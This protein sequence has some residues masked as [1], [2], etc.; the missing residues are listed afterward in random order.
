MSRGNPRQQ[1][2][3]VVHNDLVNGGAAHIH[4]SRTRH[5][6]Q[7]QQAKQALLVVVD[8][9]YFGQNLLIQRLAG[10][11]DHRLGR[12][13]VGELALELLHE[14]CLKYLEICLIGTRVKCKKT[15]F[16]HST[17]FG[18]GRTRC[19]VSLGRFFLH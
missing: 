4:Q 12:H 1:V 15:G 8:A 19:K 18:E 10:D 2:Q 3:V 13:R 11:H 17:L 14:F 6:K 9:G 7:H 16:R 5:T